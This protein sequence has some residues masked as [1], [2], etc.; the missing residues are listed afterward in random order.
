MA[1]K[2][3]IAANRAN[4][5]KSSGPRS[6]DGKA[7]SRRNALRHGLSIPSRAISAY[8][9]DVI[10]LARALSPAGEEIGGAALDAADAEIDI[11]R[12]RTHRVALIEEWRSQCRPLSF[13]LIDKLDALE[14]YERRAISRRNKALRNI[15]GGR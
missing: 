1:T 9:Q 11:L 13:N 8:Q 3:Q 12:V 10:L 6:A 14:R 5:E 15:S 4:A 2:R 7:L